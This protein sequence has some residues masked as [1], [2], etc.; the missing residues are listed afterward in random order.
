VHVVDVALK[1][2]DALLNALKANLQ[3]AQSQMKSCA[4]KHRIERAFAIGDMV[5]MK[6]QSYK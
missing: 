6:L 5:Y 1:T 2:R 3:H 4:D